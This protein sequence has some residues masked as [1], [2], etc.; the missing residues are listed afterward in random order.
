[1]PKAI[2]P[3]LPPAFPAGDIPPTLR[4]GAPLPPQLR[5]EHQEDDPELSFSEAP[6]DLL[7]S[8][9]PSAISLPPQRAAA[10]RRTSWLRKPAF[11]WA[12]AAAAALAL[13]TAAGAMLLPKPQ[14]PAVAE[15]VVAPPAQPAPKQP[16]ETPQ[17][18]RRPG[19]LPAGQAPRPG[20]EP[21]EPEPPAAAPVETKSVEVRVTPA[22]AQIVAGTERLG[23]GTVTVQLAGGEKKVLAAMLAGYRTRK[24]MIDGSK[25]LVKLELT[26][27]TPIA[28]AAPKPPPAAPAVPKALDLPAVP[29]AVPTA[30]TKSF[31]SDSSSPAK[32]QPTR[33]NRPWEPENFADEPAR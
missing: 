31:E 7:A 20:S 26:P 19:E 14:L 25:A 11:G 2:L 10:P 22:S 3:E 23:E 17:R 9:A 15:V 13:G 18:E 6:G 4:N 27:D 8:D 12:V 32:A 1:L 5:G 33:G 16:L 21:A 29:A 24:V 28:A 30:P